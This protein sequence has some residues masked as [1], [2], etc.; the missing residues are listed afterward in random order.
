MQNNLRGCFL[1][2][3]EERYSKPENKAVEDEISLYVPV[4]EYSS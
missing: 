2:H 4:A 3:G 1:K